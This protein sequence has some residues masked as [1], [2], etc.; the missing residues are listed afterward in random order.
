MFRISI[1]QD[2]ETARG[3]AKGKASPGEFPWTCIVLD[4]DDNEVAACVIVPNSFDNDIS[5]GVGRVIT[6][7]HRVY[8]QK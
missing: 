5:T 2:Y 3:L 1:S 8:R 7:A 6:V 4:E